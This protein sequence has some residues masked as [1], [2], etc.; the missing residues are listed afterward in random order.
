MQNNMLPPLPP[1][2]AAQAAP[3]LSSTAASSSS[4]PPPPIRTGVSSPS[5]MI[6]AVGS[7]V[8]SVGAILSSPFRNRGPP[9]TLTP[10][11]ES[12]HISDI[13]GTSSHTRNGFFPAESAESITAQLADLY[14]Q[15]GDGGDSDEEGAEADIHNSGI[16]SQE[17]DGTTPAD[18]PEDDDAILPLDGAPEGWEIPQPPPVVLLLLLMQ[19]ITLQSGLST[20]SNQ[21]TRGTHTKATSLFTPCGAK[22][23]PKNQ[24]GVRSVNGWE[25]FYTGWSPDE[26]DQGTYA[27]S[28]ATA[29]DL[30]PKAR[31]GKLNVERL[32]TYGINDDTINSP[33]HF[34]NLLLPIHDPT[35]SGIKD[36]GR[37]PFYSRVAQCTNLYAMSKGLGTGYNHKYQPVSEMKMLKWAGVVVRHG[38]RAG[39]PMGLHYRWVPTD[40]DYDPMIPAAITLSRWRQ[41]KSVFKL[42]NNITEPQKGSPG[43]DPCNKYNLIYKAMIYNMNYFTEYWCCSTFRSLICVLCYI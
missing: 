38:A 42:N 20:C 36:Y 33:I 2:A 4:D 13:T 18:A 26:F 21:S 11:P 9:A 40:P 22:V 5:R 10:S 27:R 12:S 32:K 15:K 30:K 24:D 23:V 31:G 8:T 6:R 14:M 34:Y 25:Y 41:V 16:E 35:K 29:R 17:E 7:A 37:M 28:P 1:P 3:S 19:L 39:Q 43:Y